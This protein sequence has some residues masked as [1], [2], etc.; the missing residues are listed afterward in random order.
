MF[1]IYPRPVFLMALFAASLS[2]WA[3]EADATTAADVAAKGAQYYW[4][5]SG[6]IKC[7][8]DYYSYSPAVGGM[9][10]DIVEYKNVVIHPIEWEELP[11][12]DR[13]NGYEWRAV[14]KMGYGF[15]RKHDSSSPRWTDWEENRHDPE[16]IT[17][18]KRFGVVSISY[19]SPLQGYPLTCADIPKG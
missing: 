15:S 16:A 9:I 14:T 2:F 17:I 3:A 6:F 18:E 4:Q 11:P 10:A 5:A 12:V 1:S 8:G 7:G 13:L 19:D